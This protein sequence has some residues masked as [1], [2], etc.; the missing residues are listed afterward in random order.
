VPGE[1]ESHPLPLLEALAAQLRDGGAQTEAMLDLLRCMHPIAP[2][3]WGVEEARQEARHEARQEEEEAPTKRDRD[4]VP[5][6]SAIA[7][8]T[9]LSVEQVGCIDRKIQRNQ[10]SRTMRVGGALVDFGIGLYPFASLLN[11]S[12]HANTSFQP[13]GSGRAMLVRATRDIA[14]GEECTDSYISLSRVGAGR[15]A[16]LQ[17]SHGF[18]CECE[19][20]AAPRCSELHELERREQSLICPRAHEAAAA[21]A[22][23]LL[24][25]DEP[26]AEWPEY[27]CA[28]AGCTVR[29]SAE[30]ARRCVESAQ[31]SFDSLHERLRAGQ[32]E[33]GCDAAGQA[34]RA[35]S[36][37][38]GPQH[39]VWMRWVAAAMELGQA[40]DDEILLL[41]AYARKEGMLQVP[42][43]AADEDAFVRVNHALVAGLETAE[44]E[45]ALRSAFC[46]DSLMHGASVEGFIH[47][48]IDPELDLAVVEAREILMRPS[49][50]ST[51]PSSSSVRTVIAPIVPESAV[52]SDSDDGVPDAD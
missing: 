17:R 45:A 41:R 11:H 28:A 20:C 42:S 19:R 50:T 13:I 46:I 10:M 43:R 36:L 38:I 22:E 35:A 15:R 48:W 3:E 4:V 1:D 9:S 40:A 33:G 16:A 27:T 8:A 49:C 34:E 24:L 29:L 44:G 2:G 18:L 32:Y 21:A 14:A 7:A 37:V 25:P 5:I 12:C 30:Q 23:H 26:Y 52:S 51:L 6:L 31:R 47:R 39:E